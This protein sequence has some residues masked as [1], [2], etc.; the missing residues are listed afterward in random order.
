MPNQ[1][2]HYSHTHHHHPHGGRKCPD[3]VS[4]TLTADSSQEGMVTALAV[5][6]VASAT[7]LGGPPQAPPPPGR[8]RPVC[9]GVARQAAR[10]P[11]HRRPDALAAMVCHHRRR[12]ARAITA[13]GLADT[14]TCRIEYVARAY[15]YTPA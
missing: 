2:T 8:N 11:I 14:R 6:T 5:I 4:G 7:S 13:P 9:D 12:A 15:I 1:S 10:L 3:L